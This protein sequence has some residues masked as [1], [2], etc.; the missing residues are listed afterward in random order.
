MSTQTRTSQ[1][2]NHTVPPQARTVPALATDPV[3]ERAQFFFDLELAEYRAV[4]AQAAPR[5]PISLF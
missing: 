1:C 3:A 2:T 5:E 4:I